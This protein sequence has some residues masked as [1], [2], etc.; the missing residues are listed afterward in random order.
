MPTVHTL[1]FGQTVH[2]SSRILFGSFAFKDADTDQASRVLELLYAYGIN[3]I[4]TAPGYGDAELRVGEWMEDH[5]SDFFLGIPDLFAASTGDL[6]VLPHILRAAAEF[7]GSLADQDMR[8]L[9]SEQSMEP[10]FS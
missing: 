3:H 7:Q 8:R 2:R 10:L 6:S 9:V 5:R 4:D 1:P